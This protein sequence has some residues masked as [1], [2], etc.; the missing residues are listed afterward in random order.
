MIERRSISPG[1]PSPAALGNRR[2]SITILGFCKIDTM[3]N[4]PICVG[5][6]NNWMPRTG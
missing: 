1:E 3:P 4:W 6:W 5:N 2:C